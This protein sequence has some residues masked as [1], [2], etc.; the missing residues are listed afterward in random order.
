MKFSKFSI[1]LFAKLLTFNIL[2]FQNAISENIDIAIDFPYFCDLKI[3]YFPGSDGSGYE[4]FH[5]SQ[6]N[7]VKAS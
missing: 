4:V 6:S 5:Q 7:E 2:F 1:K 3:S